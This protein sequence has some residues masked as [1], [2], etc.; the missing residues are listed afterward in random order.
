MK[1][2]LTLILCLNG[3]HAGEL[4]SFLLGYER[5]FKASLDDVS[6]GAQF[7]LPLLSDEYPILSMH[8]LYSWRA[9]TSYFGFARMYFNSP[10]LFNQHFIYGG[11][12]FL[13]HRESEPGIYFEIG[14]GLFKK[15]YYFNA[16]LIYRLNLD[17]FAFR[18]QP[19]DEFPFTERKN[20]PYPTH[21]ISIVFNIF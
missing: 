20:S 11:G 9:S 5:G 1:K 14:I 2:I 17:G 4:T 16:D 10:L 21:V 8:Y 18:D 3:M 13:R 19:R 7:E 15:N 12:L 6:L